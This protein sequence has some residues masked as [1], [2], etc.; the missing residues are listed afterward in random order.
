LEV[1]VADKRYKDFDSAKKESEQEPIQVKLNE[2]IYTFPPA[3]PARTVLAQMRWMDESGTM[4]TAA[5]PEWLSSIVGEETMEEILEEGATWTQLEELL[6]YLL[7]EYQ[8]VQD[9]D[10]EVEVEPEE[11]ED[12]TPK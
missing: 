8:I 11:G 6:Q 10:E 7:Q 3:L 1:G 9:V 2:K 12:D 5:V 4:P